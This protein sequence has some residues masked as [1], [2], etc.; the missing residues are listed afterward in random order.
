M[1]LMMW[2]MGRHA[3]NQPTDDAVTAQVELDRM[4]A[5]VQQ[6]RAARGHDGQALTR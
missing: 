2:M 5:E 6:L 3:T 4:R 1:A